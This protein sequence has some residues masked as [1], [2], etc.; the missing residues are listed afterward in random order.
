MSEATHVDLVASGHDRRKEKPPDSAG[1]FEG[2]PRGEVVAYRPD[3]LRSISKS[4]RLM[5]ESASAS[6]CVLS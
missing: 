4:L 2:C 1:G 3:S 5:C 6:S